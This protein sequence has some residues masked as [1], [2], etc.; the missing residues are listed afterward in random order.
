VK[1]EQPLVSIVVITYNSSKYVLETL[2]SAK[3]QTYENIELIISDDGSTDETIVI[4]QEWLDKSQSEFVNTK[5]ITVKNN[6]GIPANCNRGV[7]ASQGEWIKIIAGDD[8]LLEECISINIKHAIISNKALYF[9]KVEVFNDEQI[10]VNETEKLNNTVELFGKKNIIQK[11]KAYI[12]Y[13][14]MINTPSFFIQKKVLVTLTFFDE[15]Y[16]LLED[17][18]FLLKLFLN[19][20]EV[21]LIDTITVK[22]R[23]NNDSVTRKNNTTRLFQEDLL[24][25]YKSYSRPNLD[26]CLND[27]IFKIYRDLS[28]YFIFKTV[29]QRHIF[30]FLPKDY[31]LRLVMIVKTIIYKKFINNINL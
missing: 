25:A 7:K 2:E 29:D 26:K 14:I 13:P 12:R 15:N 23:F 1:A 21:E 28:F 4:C 9:S 3:A 8:I 24:K 27:K 10:L 17:Q 30:T 19:Q 31:F 5:L 22:Y 6:S 20:Y 11:R 16:K 18:P